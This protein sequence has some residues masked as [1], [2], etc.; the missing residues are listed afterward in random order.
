[1]TPQV[2]RMT[3][4]DVLTMSA[5][6]PALWEDKAL[7]GPHGGDPV[8]AIVHEVDPT[9]VGGFAY[10]NRE[11][12]LVGAILVRATGMPVLDYARSRL[13]EPLGIDSDPAQEPLLLPTETASFASYA[14]APGFVWP[15]D[16]SGAHTAYAF[17]KLRLRDL[18]AIGQ[19]YLQHG[20]WHGRQVVPADWVAASTRTQLDAR[21]DGG[22]GYFWWIG[23]ADGSPCFFAAGHAGQLI[24]VVPD[25]QL[26]VAVQSEVDYAHDS[27][28]AG[29]SLP[30]LNFAVS[31]AIA[32]SFSR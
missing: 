7:M 28:N 18:A 8:D 30:N 19:L 32:P 9:I 25:R 29:I 17:L 21:D 27:V 11:A 6:F 23:V 12:Q 26:V 4:R 1:M 15:V 20:R 3:L 16:R 22:Y 5:G 13:L 24:E 2:A 31:D 10:S 14:A